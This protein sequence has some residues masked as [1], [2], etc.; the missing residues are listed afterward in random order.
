MGWVG[1]VSLGLLSR[2]GGF[3]GRMQC[4]VLRPVWCSGSAWG[5]GQWAADCSGRPAQV[6]GD[7]PTVPARI[8]LCALC[9]FC[10]L[11]PLSVCALAGKW[12]FLI[13][14]SQHLHS[15][16][17]HYTVPGHRR[18]SVNSCWV[19]ERTPS[20]DYLTVFR[21]LLIGI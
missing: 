4:C 13:P 9:C 2:G 19:D 3:W 21:K 7:Q 14:R 16:P 17:P 15:W 11:V 1:V 12:T 5:E 20:K 6:T 10:C 18:C 8:F